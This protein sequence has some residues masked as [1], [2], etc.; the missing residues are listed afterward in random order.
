MCAERI[1]KL[2]NPMRIFVCTVDTLEM[3]ILKY[4]F[5]FSWELGYP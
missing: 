1:V 5:D 2:I 3:S 4:L